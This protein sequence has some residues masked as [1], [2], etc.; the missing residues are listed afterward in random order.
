MEIRLFTI[1]IVVIALGTSGIDIDLR[2]VDIDQCPLPP[3][4]LQLNIFAASDKCKKRTTECIAIPG[5]GFRRGSYRC[6]CK[7][8]FYYP[9][10]KSTERYYNG[11]VVEE[12]FEKLMLGEHSQYSMDGVFECLPCAEGC[13]YCENGS[14][15]VVSLNWLMRTALLILECCVIA[16]LPV[17]ILFTWKYGNVKTFKHSYT[18]AYAYAYF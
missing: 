13:E 3:G 11:T 10:I 17:V 8:G 18:L 16:C 12:E 6:I 5:L 1:M 15:C 7:R 2:R 9:D 4:S 14:P